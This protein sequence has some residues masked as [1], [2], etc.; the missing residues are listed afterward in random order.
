MVPILSHRVIKRLKNIMAERGLRNDALSMD[1]VI[2]APTVDGDRAVAYLRESVTDVV[3]LNCTR[4]LRHNVLSSVDRPF[5]ISM[6][7]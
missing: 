5:V 7:G 1:H 2:L 4:S 3:L 6:A